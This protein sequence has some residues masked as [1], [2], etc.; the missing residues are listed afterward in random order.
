MPGS[1][2]TTKASAA[3][4]AVLLHGVFLAQECVVASRRVG[5][6]LGAADAGG[7]AGG[8]S[9]GACAGEQRIVDLRQA[10]DEADARAHLG[11]G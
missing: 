2:W 8:G 7:G 10:E 1:P 4:V 3:A 6:A 9:G 11:V 5:V